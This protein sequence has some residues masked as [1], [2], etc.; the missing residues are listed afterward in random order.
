[1]QSRVNRQ[2]RQRLAEGK[3][4]MMVTADAPITEIDVLVERAPMAAALSGDVTGRVPL[5]VK[6]GQKVGN[7][8]I[9][10]EWCLME[11][12]CSAIITLASHLQN[13]P[14]EFSFRHFIP[15][16][17]HSVISSTTTSPT[18]PPLHTQGLPLIIWREKRKA[19]ATSSRFYDAHLQYRPIIWFH[20]WFI[21]IFNLNFQIDKV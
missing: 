12:N 21:D 14:T 19:L 8:V 5:K 7:K 20:Y 1:M 13:I 18:H 10:T 3:V 2:S 4:R 9:I 16:F 15:S 6:M 11:R 17:R